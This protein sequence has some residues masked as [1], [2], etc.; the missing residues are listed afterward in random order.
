MNTLDEI[1]V[2][3][4]YQV[5]KTL[6]KNDY[7]QIL[8]A[9]RIS[10]EKKV[11]LKQSVLLNND[12]SGVSKLG[13]EYDILKDLDHEGIPVVYDFFFDG[14]TATLVEEFIDGTDLKSLIFRNKLS[15][16]EVLVFAIQLSGILQYL[17]QKGIIHKDIN[18]GNIM[19]TANGAL[20]LLDF[21]I[22]SNL[23]YTTSE[24]PGL[25]KIEGTL[26]YISPEQTGRTAYSVT[27]SCD[28]YSLGILLYELL[29]G[30]PPFDSIDPLE[31]VHF[32]LSRKPL[33]LKTIL[34]DLPE[35]IDQVVSKLLEKDPDDRYHSATG[36]IADLEIIKKH[37]WAGKT[38]SGFKAGLNDLTE[39]YRQT[40]KLY[41]RQNEIDELIGYFSNLHNVGSL[42]VLV[43]G[44]SGVGKSSLIKHVKFPI[45][46]RQGTFIS[47][48]FDQFKKEIPYYAFIE[49][50]KEFIKN[51][52]SEPEN[53]INIWKNRISSA[54]GE[55]ARLITDVIPQL[56][57][58]IDHQPPVPKLQPAEQEARF[59]MVLLDFIYAF[60]ISESPLVFF[61]DDLQ[62]A[63]LPSLNLVKRIL[64]NPRENSIM[65]IGSY[66]DNEIDKGHP[67]LITLKQIQ[68]SGGIVKSIKLKP[69]DQ[70]TTNQIT[71][72]SFGMGHIQADELGRQVFEKTNGNPFF[73]HSFLKSLYENKLVVSDPLKHWTWNPDE[74]NKL[75]FTD[76]VIDLLA[77][78]LKDLPRPTREMLK[79]A[80]V[81][82]NTFTLTDL[83]DSTENIKP[84]VYAALKP[85][86]KGGY[87]I[88]IDTS[89]RLLALQSLNR[90]PGNIGHLPEGSIQFAFTHDKVQQA[91]YNL[92]DEK[93]R[94]GVHYKIGRLL[95]KNR[96]KAQ[97]QEDIFEVLNHFISSEHLISD[98]NEKI[99]VARYCLIAGRKAKDSASYGMGVHFL[100]VAKNLIGKNRWADHYELTYSIIIELG[101]CQYLND[102]PREAE[103]CFRELLGYSKTRFEKLQVYYIH[104][105]LYLKMGNTA[106]SLRLGFE[107]A[108]LYNI[109]YPKNKMAIQLL[110]MFT[111]VKY[112]LL[113]S[114]KYRNPEKLFHLSDCNDEE[115]IA[116]N[117]FLID[118][119]TSAY[120]QDQNLMML[121]IFKIIGNYIKHGFT[122]ASGWGFSGFSV[123]VLAALKM[124]K[125][126]F[127]LWDITIKLHQ[128][129]RSP[130]IK[131]RLSY[132]VLCFHNH[133]RYPYRDGYDKILETI[134]ACTLNGDQIFTSYSVALYLR[135]RINAGENLKE[136]IESSE[137]HITLIKN[138]KGGFD[139]FHGFYQ[140]AR[141]L[142]G[143]TLEN[144]WNDGTFDEAETIKRLETEG[145]KT[146]LAMFHSAKCNFLYVIGKYREAL[147][148][149]RKQLLYSDNILGDMQ[150]VSLAFYTSLSIS[151]CYE[152]MSGTE[153][154]KYLKVFSKHLSDMKLW[155][156]GCPENFSQHVMLMKA[157][158]AAINNNTSK[159]FMFYAKAIDLADKNRF[160]HVEAIA[161][162]RAAEFCEKHGLEMQSRIYFE[163]A[164]NAYHLWGAELVCRQLE[165]KFANLAEEKP[166]HK[167]ELKT[168]ATTHSVSTKTALDLASLL[169][170]SQSIASQVK[171]DDLL[172]K[173]MH[174]VIENAG[175]E[176]GYLLLNKGNKL[177]AE[178]K[179][180][181]G[182]NEIEILPSMPYQELK[183]IPESVINYCRRTEEIVVENEAFSEGQFTGDP[184]IS[185]NGIMS[186]MCL[187]ISAVGKIN[188]FLYLENRLIK[189]V[190]NRNRTELLK[191]LSGQIGISIENSILY[192]NLEEKVMERTREIE[193][194][195]TELKATQAQLIQ[196]EK[197][198]S[199]G[200]LTAGIA[201]EI[202]NPLNFVNNFSEISNELIIELKGERLKEKGERD[203][204]L[205]E[206]ILNDISQNL[207]KINHH[208][209]RAEA[210]VKGM[211]QHSR[212]GSGQK[213]LTDIN[214]LCDEYV[215]LSY[216]GLKAKD[217]SF[218]ASYE[219]HF[220]PD[221][222]KIEVI[223][224]DIGRVLL[225]LINNAFY[226]VSSA[227]VK[228]H[229]S[230]SP[231]A[232]SQ[233]QPD[234][235]NVIVSTQN[236]GKKIEIS[237]KDNG[238][239]IPD[240]IK[241]KIFQPFFTTKPTGQGTGLGLSLSYDI[242]KAHEGEVK[243]E[244]KEGE[245]STFIIQLPLKNGEI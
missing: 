235:P 210:I 86:I 233:S 117:K 31:V 203:E 121:V 55:N 140:M 82:G 116:L 108:K 56:S 184:F 28:L 114:T 242:V 88:S 238:P 120:Q 34:P 155:E 223:P 197:M 198:A 20:K 161:F 194:T 57:L 40:Q 5:I 74:I 37:V 49:G 62:W 39:Q 59:N 105:S 64:E 174:I 119:A 211:L 231:H 163:K 243:V 95:L 21:G 209:K 169:K 81:L 186:L 19:V 178:V 60:S 65:L 103:N 141:A 41:G 50:I 109:R 157:E 158:L 106:E 144:S 221:L 97:L 1:T 173:L 164:W 90:Q 98:E 36:L 79:Y 122:D 190:F 44:Y 132:T 94:P 213:E 151:A 83:A 189:G 24:M 35:G 99:E 85:A 138:V 29:A 214:A 154:N 16:N 130:L 75:G 7:H 142:N 96:S 76:N 220:D 217:N 207:A 230:A 170:A 9:W 2:S 104:S 107:V 25:D 18:P 212:T 191:M 195:L 67:L 129:T 84:D 100:N 165:K 205:E 93:D 162:H 193:K 46:Q 72:D 219:T 32:H 134:K 133:W 113:F 42:M 180:I 131:W 168:V 68:E 110:T 3:K 80:A 241:N 146:K 181:S 172:K 206:E 61:I 45:L 126:G 236:L 175:A 215:R 156:K 115:I 145:N 159:A 199:L 160:R 177:C 124:Q 127:N 226:A 152:T 111:L 53:K 92:I 239:G 128:R 182:T 14:N 167:Y 218:N 91:A 38:L 216:H 240:E 17:H 66:R 135:S 10:D 26:R 73:I 6:S 222:P 125:K 101:E 204:E 176:R 228:T 225:N 196:S 200:E 12:F 54:I 87:L 148:E 171:Y 232:L 11:V 202:Q 8:L 185:Q 27:H 179:G 201:H 147:D 137:E 13:H 123:V 153:K 234:N 52:L 208:G 245:G 77:F 150:E 23:H 58:I 15:F 30:K 63:D 227:S 89:Y 51:L 69:L 78:G 224:Q 192:G 33:S 22:S 237:V 187:P 188:G 229:G 48:K 47:G 112:L 143:Q 149:S 118:L 244:T 183:S 71:A 139:F 4:E 166:F 43:A 102:N 70:E 136:I